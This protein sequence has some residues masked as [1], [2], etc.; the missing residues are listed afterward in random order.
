MMNFNP[1]EFYSIN[2]CLCDYTN[3]YSVLVFQDM[4]FEKYNKYGTLKNGHFTADG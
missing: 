2:S 3:I 4:Y 1:S